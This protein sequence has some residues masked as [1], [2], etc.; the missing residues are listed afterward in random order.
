MHVMLAL[1]SWYNGHNAVPSA[2]QL[3][4]KKGWGQVTR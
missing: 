4:V 1:H 3:W 2:V